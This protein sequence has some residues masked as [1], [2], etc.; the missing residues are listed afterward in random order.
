MLT[1]KQAHSTKYKS[2]FF[3][4]CTL[5]KKRMNAAIDVGS[6]PPLKAGCPDEF[7]KKIL[8]KCSQAHLLSKLQNLYRGKK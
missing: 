3:C 2:A 1:T 8:P 6:V 5:A 4:I 7:V